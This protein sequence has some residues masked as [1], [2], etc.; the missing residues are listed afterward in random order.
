MLFCRAGSQIR[1]ARP[2][3]ATSTMKR[4]PWQISLRQLRQMPL[5][6]D[7]PLRS[8]HA[9]LKAFSPYRLMPGE[10]LL[11]P[12]K[13][14]Q[15]L[16]LLLEGQLNVYLES[17]DSHSISTLHPG[18]CVGELSFIDNL[19]PSAYVI[20]PEPCQILRLHHSAL[21]LLSQIAPELMRNL[22]IILCSRT[23]RADRMF[24]D[25]ELSANIDALT[26]IYNRRWLEH[27]FERE[28]TRNAFDQRPLSLLMLDV[29]HFKDYN[30]QHGHLAGDYALSMVA[31]TLSQQLR[32]HDTLVRYGGEEF[33]ILMPSVLD[34]A[35]VIGERMRSALEQIEW[36]HSQV[37]LLP[38]VTISIGVAQHHPK[39]SLLTLIARADKALY[40]AKRCGRNSLHC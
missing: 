39:D 6:H 38:G 31:H 28:N 20:A 34:E 36:F 24:R 19:L 33:V 30:D 7:V 4:A 12:F 15:Y 23:R 17:P 18:D 3:P 22:L 21:P 40:R 9:S 13:R 14:N 10:V 16:Y 37:G 25:S 27:I 32:P 26:G 8:F 29:D 11:S 2:N 1:T 35:C 5:F